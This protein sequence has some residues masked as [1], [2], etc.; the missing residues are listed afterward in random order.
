MTSKSRQQ[1]RQGT[2]RRWQ[3]G[4]LELSEGRFCYKKCSGG[5]IL[6]TC[7]WQWGTCTDTLSSCLSFEKTVDTTNSELEPLMGVAIVVAG[8]AVVWCMEVW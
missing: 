6:L 3:W 2:I 8:V 1:R 4:K 5:K 7:H